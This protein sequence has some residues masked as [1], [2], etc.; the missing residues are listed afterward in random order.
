V[1]QQ[2]PTKQIIFN[3]PGELQDVLCEKYVGMR[4]VATA[5]WSADIQHQ[6]LTDLQRI[7]SNLMTLSNMQSCTETGTRRMHG[8]PCRPS[9]SRLP[10]KLVCGLPLKIGGLPRLGSS[11]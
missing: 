8:V 10:Q 9:F 6:E 2:K 11:S 1:A 3:T 7:V 5:T 4:R